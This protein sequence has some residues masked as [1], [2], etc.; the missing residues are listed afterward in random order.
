MN[1]IFLL[2]SLVTFNGMS[3][4]YGFELTVQE[5]VYVFQPF[6]YYSDT[7][8][9][10]NTGDL[11]D[12]YYIGLISD[13]PE[14]W[15]TSLCVGG[16][17]FPPGVSVYDTLSPGGTDSIL[18]DI[19]A[20]DDSAGLP[21]NVLLVVKSL[22]DTT[23]AESVSILFATQSQGISENQKYGDIHTLI[24]VKENLLQVSLEGTEFP[25]ELSIYN[26]SGALVLKS[27]LSKPMNFIPLKD[28]SNS[29]YFVVIR[30]KDSIFYR[31]KFFLIR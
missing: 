5:T 28:L 9:L 29:I 12:I 7:V 22:G 8:V 1:T 4:G 3:P 27:E 14:G 31:G 25:Y 24:K 18:L 19:V 2:F 16:M 6:G 10:K 26:Q 23:L 13:L 21:A 30:K 15:G 11:E 20:S 17:C